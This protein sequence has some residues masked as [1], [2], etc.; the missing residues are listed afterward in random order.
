MEIFPLSQ[1]ECSI[2]FQASEAKVRNQEKRKVRVLR[3]KRGVSN[4]KK[5]E[6]CFRELLDGCSTKPWWEISN[7]NINEKKQ[8]EYAHKIGICGQEGIRNQQKEF[9]RIRRKRSMGEGR[10]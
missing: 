9:K 8:V 10:L 1:N 4:G 2:P 6:S 5:A 7:G 3:R